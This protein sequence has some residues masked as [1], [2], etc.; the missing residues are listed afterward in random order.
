[1][2]YK[3]MFTI[4]SA[5]LSV[6]LLFIKNTPQNEIVIKSIGASGM[7]LIIVILLTEYL[8]TIKDEK[9]KQQKEWDFFHFGY[10]FDIGQFKNTYPDWKK[11]FNKILKKE[12]IKE[13][14]KMISQ[15]EEKRIKNLNHEFN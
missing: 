2:K 4:L 1:M 12:T 9:D 10:G 15:Y 8:M 13:Y 5:A 6:S 7:V 14:E 11:R 3:I